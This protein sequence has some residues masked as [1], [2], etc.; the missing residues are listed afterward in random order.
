MRH[1]DWSVTL[2]Q[3][4]Q[5][6]VIDTALALGNP[7]GAIL[8]QQL[9]QVFEVW[10]TRS[11]WH[12]IDSSEFFLRGSALP[13]E[14]PDSGTPNEIALNAWERIRGLTDLNSYTFRWLGD[15][16]QESALASADATIVQRYELLMASIEASTAQTSPYQVW[17]T[18]QFAADAI[19]LATA[20]GGVPIF[21]LNTHSDSR[22]ALAVH[23]QNCRFKVTRVD[24]RSRSQTHVDVEREHLRTLYVMCGLAPILQTLAS[25]NQHVVVA[26]LLAP[27]AVALKPMSPISSIEA[28]LA[29][30]D[31]LSL[32][33]PAEVMDAWREASLIWYEL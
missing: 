27:A 24:R 17:D 13:N 7:Y 19:A 1:P 9:S 6:C 10:M 16:I 18:S 31:D 30:S 14:R 21:S 15:N 4:R 11:F 2:S 3:K 8:V 28:D 33:P 20:L 22:H 5:T 23:A 25:G 12:C 29:Q 26:H 32:Q